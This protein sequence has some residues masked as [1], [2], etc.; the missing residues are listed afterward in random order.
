MLIHVQKLNGEYAAVAA[1][2]PARF[3]PVEEKIVLAPMKNNG[4]QSE[5]KSRVPLDSAEAERLE[6]IRKFLESNF[7]KV[8]PDERE[9]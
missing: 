3:L 7:E 2:L 6:V 1:L 5:V 9:Q 8:Y 4:E